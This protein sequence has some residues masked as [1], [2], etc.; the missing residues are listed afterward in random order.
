MVYALIYSYFE[1]YMRRSL[2]S[3]FWKSCP[4]FAMTGAMFK[5]KWLL[6]AH[7]QSAKQHLML[8]YINY[9]NTNSTCNYCNIL[10]FDFFFWFQGSTFSEM[11]LLSFFVLFLF[12]NSGSTWSDR[13]EYFLSNKKIHRYLTLVYISYTNENI[14]KKECF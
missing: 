8:T 7:R 3:S 1:H 2:G 14:E 6:Y 9:L 13:P 4:S 5:T 11:A 10:L 12:W